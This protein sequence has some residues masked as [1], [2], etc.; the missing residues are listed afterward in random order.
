MDPAVWLQTR[1]RGHQVLPSLRGSEDP[2]CAERFALHGGAC[3]VGGGQD[4]RAWGVGGDG[5]GRG[6]SKVGTQ[7]AGPAG[8]RWGPLRPEGTGVRGRHQDRRGRG[9]QAGGEWRR[10][11]VKT[12]GVGRPAG[13]AWAAGLGSEPGGHGWGPTV[14]RVEGGVSWGQRK[15]GE[16]EGGKRRGREEEEEGGWRE[17]E[18]KG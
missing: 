9:P 4:T 3:A 11:A 8:M 14:V 1:T 15:E 2:T 7:E 6:S 10:G 12:C 13:C 18:R 5:G 16:E 17:E